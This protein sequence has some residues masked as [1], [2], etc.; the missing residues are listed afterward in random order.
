MQTYSDMQNR[1]C[2]ATKSEETWVSFKKELRIDAVQDIVKIDFQVTYNPKSHGIELI[3]NITAIEPN[4]YLLQIWL[5]DIH[6]GI[7]IPELH[8]WVLSGVEF[9]PENKVTSALC[10]LIDHK[11][12]KEDAGAK[13]EALLSGYVEQNGAVVKFEPIIKQF[14]YPET[15]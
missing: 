5:K 4:T 10:G 15:S 14:V 6:T 13:Y 8:P 12:R 9:K 11:W 2:E 7:W 3:A 1:L